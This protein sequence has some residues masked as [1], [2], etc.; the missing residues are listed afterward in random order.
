MPLVAHLVEKPEYDQKTFG[1]RVLACR[2]ED[3][4]PVS[5]EISIIMADG[6]PLM[7]AMCQVCSAQFK[8]SFYRSL[9]QS[10]VEAVVKDQKTKLKKQEAHENH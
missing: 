5:K 6:K 1:M 8:E 4:R 3:D 10:G 9:I 7:I 2:S